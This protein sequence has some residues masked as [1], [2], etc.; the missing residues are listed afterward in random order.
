MCSRKLL[1]AVWILRS[2]ARLLWFY[3]DNDPDT[4]DK[5]DF[6]NPSTNEHGDGDAVESVRW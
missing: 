4:N 1:L 3:S 2:W 6:N 5:H